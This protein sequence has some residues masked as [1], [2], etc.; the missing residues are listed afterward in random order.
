MRGATRGGVPCSCFR[1]GACSGRGFASVLVLAGVGGGALCGGALGGLAS[2]FGWR[3]FVFGFSCF[4]LF[5]RFARRCALL[6]RSARADFSVLLGTPLSL[7]ALGSSLDPSRSPWPSPTWVCTDSLFTFRIF[8]FSIGCVLAVV[9]SLRD[10]LC[11][12]VRVACSLSQG[13]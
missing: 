3:G 5:L 2:R 9:T 12:S 7:A 6:L 13:L 4:G 11:S 8:R 1:F 10:C